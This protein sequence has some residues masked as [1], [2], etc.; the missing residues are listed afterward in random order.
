MIYRCNLTFFAIIVYGLRNDNITRISAFF[1][2][3]RYILGLYSQSPYR[4]AYTIN[5]YVVCIDYH[6]V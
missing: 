5:L 2:C 1:I 3:Y 4:I 6:I